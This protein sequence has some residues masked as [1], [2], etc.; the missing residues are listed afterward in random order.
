MTGKGRTMVNF[1]PPSAF[2]RALR[3]QDSLYEVDV[4]ARTGRLARVNTGCQVMARGSE[5][6]RV[7]S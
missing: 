7:V 6:R 1:N 5:D 2:V 3:V 4:G